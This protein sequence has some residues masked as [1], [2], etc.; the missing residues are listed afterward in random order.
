MIIVRGVRFGSLLEYYQRANPSLQ[1]R[2]D[3]PVVT[4]SFEWGERPVLVA[5]KLLRL[6]LRVEPASLPKSMRCLAMVP[7]A[8]RAF[9]YAKCSPRT[10]ETVKNAGFSVSPGLWQPGESE[11]VQLTP[12]AL[13]FG[14]GKR[15][16][17]PAENGRKAYQRYFRDREQYLREYGVYR[18][19]PAAARD[20]TVVLPRT[21]RGWSLETQDAYVEGIRKDLE[22]LTK[23]NFTLRLESAETAKDIARLLKP[24]VAGTCLIVF[25]DRELGGAG[26][27]LLSDELRDWTLK[28]AVRNTVQRAWERIRSERD[29]QRR[30][31]AEQN[32]RDMI[33]HTVLDLLD[34]M[35]VIPFRVDQWPYD[36]CL[37]I[38]VSEDRRYCA[39]SFLI[40][41]DP[42]AHPG[43][44][45]LWRYLDCWTKPDTRRETIERFQLAE[46]IAAIPEALHGHRLS[47]LKSLL[48]LRDGH[49][50]GDEPRAIDSGL[51]LWKKA[52]VL[53]QGALIDVVDYHKRTVKDLR[54]W[55]LAG[56]EAENVLEGRAVIMDEYR[57]IT[58]LTGAGTLGRFGTADPLLLVTREPGRIR[59]AASGVFALAQHNWLSPKK[60]YR[61]AQPM[62][63]ADVEL[64]RRMAMEVRGLR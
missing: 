41:R 4:V 44:D 47:P 62:R 51:D 40:C 21:G 27:Y 61:D 57:A 58:A 24:R 59:R 31:Q 17:A 63:D 32:W 16:E 7:E 50:C 28:R 60:A 34:Q 55:L 49:E 43:R 13:L 25:D 37:A 48:V 53:A 64:T 10:I 9:S 19:N 26:Y 33:F 11:T 22:Q 20:I 12:P 1:I 5:A 18:F 42:V 54:M 36:A 15:L 14:T 3:D 30:A 6:R 46:K 39:L 29:P 2:R 56:R 45:G 23:K 8:R 52:D 38:D 35:G